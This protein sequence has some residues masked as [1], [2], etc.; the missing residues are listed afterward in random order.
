MDKLSTRRRRN[1]AVLRKMR[2]PERLTTGGRVVEERRLY[3]PFIPG[4]SIEGL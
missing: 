1:V 2:A 4:S 3:P